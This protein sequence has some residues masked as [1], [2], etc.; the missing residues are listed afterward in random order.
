MSN[1]TKKDEKFNKNK[2]NKK[3]ISPL[4]LSWCAC[5]GYEDSKYVKN[6]QIG[7][8]V[9]ELWVPNKK[10]YPNGTITASCGQLTTSSKTTKN[11]M[12]SPN[13][14]YCQG[15]PWSQTLQHR[16][17]ATICLACCGYP[18]M[19]RT[20][21]AQTCAPLS[22]SGHPCTVL[23]CTVLYCTVLYCTYLLRHVGT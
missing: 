19:W 7:A 22:H 10:C 15:R 2:T 11:W 12:I 20:L 4:K 18:D 14:I 1:R 9:P 23:Y 5:C 13:D 16:K 3:S 21:A 6:F 17:T 8:V